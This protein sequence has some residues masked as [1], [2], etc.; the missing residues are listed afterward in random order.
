[1]ARVSDLCEPPGKAEVELEL[2]AARL[3]MMMIFLPPPPLRILQFVVAPLSVEC[4]SRPG[5]KSNWRDSNA[6]SPDSICR[7]YTGKRLRL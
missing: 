2:E 7:R 4:T 6:A 1:M 5:G 3:P